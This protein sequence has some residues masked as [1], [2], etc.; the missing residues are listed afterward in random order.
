MF[1]CSSPGPHGPLRPLT[2]VRQ[3][4]SLGVDPVSTYPFHVSTYPSLSHFTEQR[5]NMNMS[6]PTRFSRPSRNATTATGAAPRR[7]TIRSE[8]I[9]NCYAAAIA[10]H[11]SGSSWSRRWRCPALLWGGPA[12]AR[13]PIR[14]TIQHWHPCGRALRGRC[15]TLHS[16][17]RCACAVGPGRTQVTA[18]LPDVQSMPR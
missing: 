18:W 9:W 17:V 14:P 7:A 16:Q 12:P 13:P 8:A 6:S 5:D 10:G 4:P 1:A 11:A 15:G 2:C 3:D